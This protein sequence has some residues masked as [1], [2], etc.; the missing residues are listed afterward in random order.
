MG[1]LRNPVI[2]V[3]LAVV[4]GGAP[5]AA[6]DLLWD[7]GPTDGSNGY[8][9]AVVDVFGFRRTLLEDFTIADG[10]SWEI[11]QLQWTHIW[12]VLIDPSGMGVE[13]A[14]R[15]DDAGMPGAVIGD[16]IPTGYMEVE[17]GLEWFGRPEMMSTGS[18][19]PFVLGPGTYWFEATIV[20]TDNNFWMARAEPLIGAE[21]WV[22]YDDLG[23]LLSGS[24]IFGVAANLNFG[25]WGTLS[26]GEVEVP[27]DVKPGGCPNPINL[28]NDRGKLPA[29]VLGTADF[30]VTML[31]PAT[32][33]LQGVAP[34]RWGYGDVGTPYE[35]F[36]G[37][38]DCFDCN[39]MGPDGFLDLKLKFLRADIVAA[40]GDVGHGDCVVLTLTGSLL[41]GTPVVGED[42]V[43]VMHPPLAR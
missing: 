16:T 13:V 11:T 27:V 19:E 8:S 38:D 39:E 26:G 31:D 17:T 24:G 21:C 2:A 43:L 33:L 34:I 42:V 18:F 28:K 14:F 15:M 23:G 25:L 3:A 36:T 10:E 7:N 35:P 12:N 20:G 30:D 6:Q 1:K 32:V 22:N 37:K 5:A 41:D 4:L 40:I 29:A 9:N